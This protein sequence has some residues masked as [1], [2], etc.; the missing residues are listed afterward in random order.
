MN[1]EENKKKNSKNG[2]LVFLLIVAIIIIVVM[3]L[4]IYRLTKEKT[5]QA[6]KVS[7]LNNQVINLETTINSLQENLNILSSTIQNNVENN[8]NSSTA[9]EIKYEE[10]T[11]AIYNQIPENKHFV[12]QSTEQTESG[13]ILL[14][15]RIYEDME[16]TS[17]SKEEYDSLKATGEITLFGEKF[18][19]GEYEDVVPGYILRNSNNYGFY[20]TDSYELVNFSDTSFVQGTDEYYTVTL[21][22]TVKLKLPDDSEETINTTTLEMI[23]DN[24]FINLGVMYDFEFDNGRLSKIIYMM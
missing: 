17:I 11:E 13:N 1:M 16:L 15:G 8:S 18:S 14:K 24:N 2:L 9:D 7:S 21:D 19:L 6:E 23:K 22:D 5:V 4:Y 3:A 10:L 12:I 20:V